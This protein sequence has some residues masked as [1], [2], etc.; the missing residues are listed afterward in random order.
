MGSNL[1]ILK[2]SAA[3]FV[4]RP[5]LAFYENSMLNVFMMWGSHAFHELSINFYLYSMLE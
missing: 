1:S 2:G 3:Q 4:S 5:D